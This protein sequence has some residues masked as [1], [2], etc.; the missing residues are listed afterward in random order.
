MVNISEDTENTAKNVDEYVRQAML[1]KGQH[2]QCGQRG[3]SVDSILLAIAI[4]Y[5]VHRLFAA[6]GNNK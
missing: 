3:P 1:I 4:E 5:G 6:L 2:E